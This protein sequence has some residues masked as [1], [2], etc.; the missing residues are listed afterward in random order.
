[1]KVYLLFYSSWLDDGEI[2]G[3][4]SSYQKAEDAIPPH[5][6]I[7][8]YDIFQTELDNLFTWYKVDKDF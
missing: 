4:Y 1:M 7:D 2:Y 8:Y 6:D 3:V 5:E